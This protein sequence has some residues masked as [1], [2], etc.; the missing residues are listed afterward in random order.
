MDNRITCLLP[1]A[2]FGKRV[3]MRIN[4]SKELTIDPET[5]QPLIQWHIDLCKKYN[6]KPLVITRKEKTDL[7]DWCVERSIDCIIVRHKE[8][9]MTSL[10]EAKDYW[11][12]KNI[13]LLPDTKFSDTSVLVNIKKSL[14]N[15][16]V[17]AAK[18]WVTDG[19]KWGMMI[20]RHLTTQN[21]VIFEK[22]SIIKIGWAW[23]T[24]AFKKEYG[25][26]LLEGLKYNGQYSGPIKT[27]KLR[28]FKDV[29][30]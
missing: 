15:N 7:I 20:D 2:G 17:V 6:L 21:I 4:Q 16:K 9:W 29:T 23:G 26:A 18:H 27:Y 12:E 28:W 11:G 24:L 1:C 13:L 8:E 22:S 19:D 3:G 5:N 30:R 14:E 25:I 10:L